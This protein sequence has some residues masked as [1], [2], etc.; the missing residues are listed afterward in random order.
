MELEQLKGTTHGASIRVDENAFSHWSGMIIGPKG[1][2]YEGGIFTLDLIFPGDYPFAPPRVTF[3]TP[4]FHPNVSPTGAICMDILKGGTG[5]WSPLLSVSSLLISIESL[6]N[7]PNPDDP[8]NT[9]AADLFIRDRLAYD[10]KAK[11]ETT[12]YAKVSD[13]QSAHILKEDPRC[14]LQVSRAGNVVG[15]EEAFEIT[16]AASRR[17]R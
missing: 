11:G 14:H 8:L 10:E 6:L 15:E 3:R 13:D 4:I 7:D 16:L 2:P 1:S 9:D 17:I 5:T 12:K